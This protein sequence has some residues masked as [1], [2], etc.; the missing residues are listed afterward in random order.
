M[1]DY[2]RV[3]NNFP[4]LTNHSPFSGI[5]LYLK[6]HQIPQGSWFQ[7]AMICH[8]N[9]GEIQHFPYASSAASHA[10]EPPD[11]PPRDRTWM[12]I[13]MASTSPST[14]LVAS[15]KGDMNGDEWGYQSDI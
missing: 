5:I 2:Q 14:W 3:S 7:I 4:F 8:G 13:C 12:V 1:F 11:F 15:A 6:Y 9:L 10:L